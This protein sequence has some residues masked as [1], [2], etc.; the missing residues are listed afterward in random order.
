LGAVLLL[1]RQRAALSTVTLGCAALLKVYPL[2]LAPLWLRGAGWPRRVQAWAGVAGAVGLGWLS[3]WP[4]RGAEGR[5]LESLAYVESRWR[6]NNASLYALLLRASGSHDLAAGV[7]LGV[8]AG[9]AL[10]AAA[11][12]VPPER[13]AILLI[14]V[15]LLFSANAFPW[16]FTWAVPLLCMA[17]LGRFSLAW[18]LLTVTQFVSYHVLIRYQTLGEWHFQPAFLLLT[19]APPALLLLILWRVNPPAPKPSM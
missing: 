11:R 1:A 18:L 14:A 15:L 2:V 9:L 16:Y 6:L 19:Y 4:F 5:L 13:A 8:V 10:W 7:A 17:P 12:N 3:W